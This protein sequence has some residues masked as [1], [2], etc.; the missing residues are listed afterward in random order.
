VTDHSVAQEPKSS[1]LRKFPRKQKAGNKGRTT[2]TPFCSELSIIVYMVNVL[3]N[4]NRQVNQQKRVL[5]KGTND[6]ELKPI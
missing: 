3:L 5:G 6:T 4:K 1:S 2:T